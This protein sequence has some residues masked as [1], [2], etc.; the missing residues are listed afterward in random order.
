MNAGRGENEEIVALKSQIDDAEN[1]NEMFKGECI[2]NESLFKAE[3]ENLQKQVKEAKLQTK[4]KLEELKKVHAAE[5]Q[6]VAEK[7]QKEIN[8][9]K[10]RIEAQSMGLDG[11]RKHRDALQRARKEA[12][13]SDLKHQLDILKLRR[14]EAELEKH[15]KVKTFNTENYNKLQELNMKL[16]TLS[17]EIGEVKS[18]NQNIMLQATMKQRETETKYKLRTEENERN[19][20]EMKQKFEQK[21]KEIDDLVEAARENAQV[22]V[23]QYQ[24]ELASAQEQLNTMTTLKESLRQKYTY[25]IDSLK[26]EINNA[27]EAVEKHT[28]RLKEQAQEVNEQQRKVNEILK[29]NVILDETIRALN[30]DITKTRRDNNM[31]KK[32]S[33][34]M[35]TQIYNERLGSFRKSSFF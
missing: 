32:E 19:L 2:K 3:I 9:I 27:K 12:E 16:E 21:Q 24:S 29:E 22:T 17:A 8:A 25:Q 1:R 11:Y 30:E 28:Q 31:L 20:A 14:A 33:S 10:E 13:K 23:Q 26:E 15:T 35:E 6:E 4:E 18:S 5:I 34:R 7:E